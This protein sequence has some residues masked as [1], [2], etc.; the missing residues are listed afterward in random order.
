MIPM[1]CD[2]T[3]LIIIDIQEKLVATM[4]EADRYLANTQFL[5]KALSYL[6]VKTVVTEQ[7]PKG[8]GA[9]H[10]D[11]IPYLKAAPCYAKTQFNA[12]L[13]QVLDQI[14]DAI[15]HIVL[16]GMETSICVEQ[17]AH[18]LL[19]DYPQ[20]EVHLIRDAVTARSLQ[21]H[22]WALQ[23]LR[24]DGTSIISS[25]SFIYRLLADAKHPHF[26]EIIKLVKERQNTQ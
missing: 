12:C 17:T 24:H 25:E 22:E 18:Q 3:L 7:Y 1:T 19:A 14:D 16:I 9:T 2:N 4:P 20:L 6:S 15:Q 10:A 21:E 8:L 13:P 26:K 5:L 23:Q 11:L